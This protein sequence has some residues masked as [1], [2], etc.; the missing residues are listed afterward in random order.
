MQQPYISKIQLKNY[1]SIRDLTIECHAGLNIMIGPNGSGKTNFVN[2]LYNL[3]SYLGIHETQV[4]F[5]FKVTFVNA[6]Q[7]QVH[8]FGHWSEKRLR[9]APLNWNKVKIYQSSLSDSTKSVESVA[10]LDFETQDFLQEHELG[11]FISARQIIG[12]G[13][14]AQLPYLNQLDVL[15]VEQATNDIFLGNEPLDLSYLNKTNLIFKNGVT[16][17]PKKSLK[18]TEKY[19]RY[20]AKFSPIQ[21]CRISDGYTIQENIDYLTINHFIIEFYVNNRWHT[22]NELSDGTKRLFY[23]ITSTLNAKGLVVLEEP[24]LGIHPDQLYQLM[25]FLKEQA[26]SKQI[27]I[28]T[29][30]PDALNLLNDNEL[31][32]IIVTRF[33]AQKGTQMHHLSPT[34]IQ[35]ALNY[36][37]AAGL[38]LKDYWVHSNLEDL[39]EE[40]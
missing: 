33:D 34:K 4:G 15:R 32:R 2:A 24:E 16:K 19:I 37:D 38:A 11:D 20:L 10:H 22:W 26:E 14:P 23:M 40:T 18:L 6:L 31:H 7:K 13:V 5:E 17:N 12:Y 9:N 36:M 21:N 39:D 3:L 35:E 25:A 8:W 27:I 30:A 29:H 28:T 1:K